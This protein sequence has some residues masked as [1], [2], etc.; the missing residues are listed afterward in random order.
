[1]AQEDSELQ[2]NG[3]NANQKRI[4]RAIYQD[5]LETIGAKE[6]LLNT[7]TA[8]RQ[9]KEEYLNTTKV[10]LNKKDREEFLNI[11]SFSRDDRE[12]IIR[13]AA[14]NVFKRLWNAFWGLF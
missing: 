7:L 9:A 10:H 2:E 6:L 11:V 3:M 5:S 14:Q 4:V 12:F 13:A 8:S 1:M